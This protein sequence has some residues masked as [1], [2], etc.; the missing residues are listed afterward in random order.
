MRFKFVNFK[1]N[2]TIFKYFNPTS[3]VTSLAASL[4]MY[5]NVLLWVDTICRHL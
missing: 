2:C 3:M 5:T 1:L 4:F